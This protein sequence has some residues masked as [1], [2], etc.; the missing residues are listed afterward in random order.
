MAG[1]AGREGELGQLGPPSVLCPRDV[2]HPWESVVDE[3]TRLCLAERDTVA[4][5]IMIKDGVQLH[6][7]DAPPPL[8]VTCPKHLVTSGYQEKVILGFIPD[9]IRDGYVQEFF[10]PIP[11]HFSRMFSVPK[12]LTDRRPIIDLSALNKLLRKVSFK[13]EDL[14]KVARSLSPGLWAVKLDLKDAYLHLHLGLE[15]VKYF[16]FALGKRIFAFLVLPFGLSPAPWLFTRVL[17]P[18]KKALR[19]LGIR[20]TS[21]L[22]DFLILAKSQQEALEHVK[23][24]IGLLQRL[25]FRINWKKSVLAPQRRLEYL[26][27][28]LNLEEMTFSLPQEKVERVLSLVRSS[29]NPFLKRS[30]LESLVGFLSFTAAYLPLGKLW[31][32]PLLAWMNS[33]SSPLARQEWIATD[34]E[35]REALRPW[36][37]RAFLESSVPMQQGCP[38]RVLM[39]DASMWGWG[40]VVAPH[41]VCGSWDRVQRTRSINWLELKAIHLSLL[42]FRPLLEGKCVSLRADNTTA[43]ACIRKQGSLISPELWDLSRE[44]LILA[45]QSNIRLV[46]QHLRGVLNV[47]ADK[48]SRES[49]VSTEWSLDQLTFESLCEAHGVPQV[50]LM[51]TWENHKIARYVSPCPDVKACGIDAFSCD[52]NRWT[53][54]YLFSPFQLPLEVVRRLESFRGKGFLIAPLWPSALWFSPL[55]GRCPVRIPLRE[56]HQLSQCT[57]NGEVFLQEVHRYSLHV[58]HL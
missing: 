11:L 13:M 51:A 54:V 55:V 42:H 45:W 27:V 28:I 25:G 20:I 26:G 16:G 44:I 50:D 58:W 6:F 21:F 39:T 7:A 43:L 48:A 8:L 52:W 33:H 40:G 56:G 18:V 32:K 22:D 1:R 34:L 17:K 24:V 3:W 57:S 49:P 53:S 47:L 12:G 35:L 38:S 19:R 46:P 41:Q 10:L 4:F 29:G 2:A 9:W 31:M 14:G 15:V 37:D 23:I 30:E 5:S 36:A